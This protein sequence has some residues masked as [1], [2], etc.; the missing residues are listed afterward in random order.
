ML[1]ILND[2]SRSETTNEQKQR[3]SS[4]ITSASYPHS[5]ILYVC[6]FNLCVRKRVGHARHSDMGPFKK[7]QKKKVPFKKRMRCSNSHFL[8]K[9]KWHTL[10]AREGSTRDDLE[11]SDESLLLMSIKG[12]LWKFSNLI[13]WC[14]KKDQLLSVKRDAKFFL[15]AENFSPQ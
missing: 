15:R 3:T 6:T 11:S 12:E 9:T 2:A 8:F 1:K 10:E 4:Q 5:Q 14:S 7:E 13:L